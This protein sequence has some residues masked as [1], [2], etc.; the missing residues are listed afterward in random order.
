[1]KITMDTAMSLKTAAMKLVDEKLP[2]KISYKLMKLVK[3]I[4]TEETFF[5]D[6]MKEIV[7]EFASKDEDGNPVFLDNGNIKIAEGKEVE[8]QEKIQELDKLE[9]EVPDTQFSLDDFAYVELT[10]RELYLLEPVLE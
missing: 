9:I 2:V 10:A 5:N 7:D 6:K 1:M 3:A 8:C 4:E